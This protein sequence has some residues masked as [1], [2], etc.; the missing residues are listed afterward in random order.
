LERER[1]VSCMSVLSLTGL[2]LSIYKKF[3]FVQSLKII[4]QFLKSILYSYNVFFDSFE[5]SRGTPKGENAIQRHDHEI[6]ITGAG[7]LL[8]GT[9]MRIILDAG[10]RYEHDLALSSNG[11]FLFIV[12]QL[13]KCAKFVPSYFAIG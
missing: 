8:N 2:L 4:F 13:H 1:L 7:Y 9:S 10:R 5:L 12:V 6:A 11:I 3:N